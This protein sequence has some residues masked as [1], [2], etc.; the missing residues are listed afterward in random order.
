MSCGW[1]NTCDC[2]VWLS[3]NGLL[4]TGHPALH[5]PF[6]LASIYLFMCFPL[7]TI[8]AVPVRGNKIRIRHEV[9][10][11]RTVL[12]IYGDRS[13]T[14]LLL[15]GWRLLRLSNIH[16]WLF[17]PCIYF[18]VCDGGGVY[19]EGWIMC[20]RRCW[21]CITSVKDDANSIEVMDLQLEWGWLTKEGHEDG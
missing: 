14:V 10:S 2:L 12:L 6:L 13:D 16:L 3:H 7:N 18:C 20:S 21:V 8:Q 5:P 9:S 17:F 15:V 4:I 11:A 19:E 1:W